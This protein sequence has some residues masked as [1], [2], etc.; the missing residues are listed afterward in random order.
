MFTRTC[1]LNTKS[2][3]LLCC[4]NTTVSRKWTRHSKKV[5]ETYQRVLRERER[6]MFVIVKVDHLTLYTCLEVANAQAVRH[7]SHPSPFQNVNM[8]IHG[9]LF[10]SSRNPCCCYSFGCNQTFLYLQRTVKEHLSHLPFLQF[11]PHV[12]GCLLRC[13]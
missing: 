6:E 11:T 7:I 12:V 1:T 2:M 10:I 13:C 3:T 9:Q 5:Q 8:G 4:M